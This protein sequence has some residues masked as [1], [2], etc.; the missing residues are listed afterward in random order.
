VWNRLGEAGAGLIS[1]RA[2]D[3]DDEA[4]RR[5]DVGNVER[6]QL[7]PAQR[8]GEADQDQGAVAQAG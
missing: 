8:R 5:R 6:N 3:G 2:S 4:F 1:L 7:G